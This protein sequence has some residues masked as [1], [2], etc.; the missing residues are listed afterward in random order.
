MG[1]PAAPTTH[2]SAAD[3]A[4]D[5]ALALEG[6]TKSFGGF[7]AVN[8]VTLSFPAGAIYGIIGPNG[9]GKTT[10]F[11]LL[12]GFLKPTRGRLRHRGDDVTRLSPEAIARRG[13]VR[14]FQITS[15]F[16]NLTV[17]ENL[18]LPI[19]RRDGGGTGF[20]RRSAWRRRHG[21]RIDDILKRVHIPA[22]WRDRSA[23]ALPYGLKRSLE[24]GISLAA[25][26]DILLLDEPTAGMTARDIVKV[27][28]LI[29]QIAEGRTV[30]V[31]EHNLGVIADL[32][33]EIVVLQQGQ[34]LTRGRYDDVRRD[35]RVIDAYLGTKGR[36]AHA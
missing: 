17:A 30:I 2:P 33:Q 24:L 32:A 5:H 8:D 12:S 22:E 9:A 11:N 25:E 3:A 6:V 19:Q 36:H 28:E 29:G 20:L 14:S 4:P 13:V 1:E 7:I 10:L 18:A 31:V 16:G 34:L 27:T 26:P 15:I 35:Q 23:N 21:P